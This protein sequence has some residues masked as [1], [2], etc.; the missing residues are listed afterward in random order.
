MRN[1]NSTE[2]S[3]PISSVPV[4]L[5]REICGELRE[6]SGQV[7]TL[8]LNN[9]RILQENQQLRQEIQRLVQMVMHTHHQVAQIS[10]FQTEP[11]ANGTETFNPGYGLNRSTVPPMPPSATPPT[12]TFSPTQMPARTIAASTMVPF[13]P[14]ATYKREDWITGTQEPLVQ[15]LFNQTSAIT[16]DLRGWRLA[17]VISLIIL[18]AFGAGF[19]IVRPLISQP[20]SK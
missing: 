19:L 4:S 17:M 16:Q 18:S 8:Q 12:T 3:A 10:E 9:Q 6:K 20:H 1:P 5:Y 15:R 14:P 7:E 11:V 2:N 13:S